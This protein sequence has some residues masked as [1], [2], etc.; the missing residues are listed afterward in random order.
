MMT[1]ESSRMQQATASPSPRMHVQ[2]EVQ[3]G[4]QESDKNPNAAGS[5]NKQAAVAA[6][7]PQPQSPQKMAESQISKG[8]LD[9]RI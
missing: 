7:V 5:V 2:D 4:L 9:I 6:S 8:Y 1:V 3:K